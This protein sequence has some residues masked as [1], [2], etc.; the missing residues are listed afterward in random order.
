M[1]RATGGN[2]DEQVVGSYD[3]HA[4]MQ[5]RKGRVLAQIAVINDDLELAGVISRIIEDRGRDVATCCSGQRAYDV[6]KH[7]R[8]DL[9][10]LDLASKKPEGSWDILTFLQ[11][12]RELHRTPVVVFLGASDEMLAKEDW[13]HRHGIQ[14]LY[15][16]F[17]FHDLYRRVDSALERTA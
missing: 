4:R 5:Q 16:P 14:T 8:Y 15:K 3:N 10:V 11:L 9:V 6:L 2:R 13:L 1:L 12:D 17:D 7:G